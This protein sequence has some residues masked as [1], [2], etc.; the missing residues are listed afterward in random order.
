MFPGSAE[1]LCGLILLMR[2]NKT[3]EYM[4]TMLDD[5]CCESTNLIL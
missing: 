4:L 5:G 3:S 2:L 1:T